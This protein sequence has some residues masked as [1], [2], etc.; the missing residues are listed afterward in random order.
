MEKGLFITFEGIE[1]SGKSTQIELVYKKLK[2]LGHKVIMTKEPGG[3]P[4][5]D[6]IRELLLDINSKD[7]HARAELLLLLASRAQHVEEKLVKALHEGT[8]I[9]CDRFA[10]SS[11]AY[12]G[13]GRGLALKEIERMNEFAT[14]GLV[15]NLTILLDIDLEKSRERMSNKVRDRFE[16]LSQEFY[17][18][19][20][21]GYLELAREHP[22]R[23]H[24]LDGTQTSESLH[25]AILK[26]ILAKIQP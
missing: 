10:D 1:G 24:V 15:P 9:L 7:L 23:I 20:C 17:T 11:I 14:N 4:L 5:A 26:L 25:N 12:Q 3:T 6:K 2:M 16:V 13:Y 19:V 18:K 21:S 22:Y 8:T